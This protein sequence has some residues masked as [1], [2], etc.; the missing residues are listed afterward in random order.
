MTPP[1]ARRL[2][3]PIE[4]PW[5]VLVLLLPPLGVVVAGIAIPQSL[6]LRALAILPACALGV[7]TVRAAIRVT[8]TSMQSVWISLAYGLWAIFPVAWVV[9]LLSAGR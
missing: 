4:L 3:E 7:A 8:S 2:G 1:A 5:W 6:A 9:A